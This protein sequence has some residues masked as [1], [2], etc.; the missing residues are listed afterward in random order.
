MAFPEY[1]LRPYLQIG[2]IRENDHRAKWMFGKSKSTSSAL[3]LEEHI[4]QLRQ[5]LEQLV[6]NGNSLTSPRS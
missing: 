2:W 3:S 6:R 5:E 4:Y 1:Q